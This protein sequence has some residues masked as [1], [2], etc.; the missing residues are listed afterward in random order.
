[1][2]TQSDSDPSSNVATSYVSLFTEW[3]QETILE[4][5]TALLDGTVEQTL[6]KPDVLEL[7]GVSLA[8]AYRKLGS[9]KIKHDAKFRRNWIAKLLSAFQFSLRP[10]IRVFEARSEKP[11]LKYETSPENRRVPPSLIV[12]YRDQTIKIRADQAISARQ[13]G[14]WFNFDDEL[15]SRVYDS[16]LTRSV[17]ADLT[18]NIKSL[19]YIEATYLSRMSQLTPQPCWE[20]DHRGA[21]FERL[22]LDVL[23][24]SGRVARHASLAEDILERTDLRLTVQSMKRREGARV[25]VSL[26]SDLT[27]QRAKLD[28]MYLPDEFVLL[29]PLTLATAAIDSTPGHMTRFDL[30]ELQSCFP[31]RSANPEQFAR[32]LHRVFIDAID[33]ATAHPTGPMWILPEAL[34]QFIRVYAESAAIQA[35]D[36]LRTREAVSGQWRGSVGRFTT[37]H[38]I[39]SFATRASAQEKFLDRPKKI[40]SQ[41]KRKLKHSVHHLDSL[42]RTAPISDAKCRKRGLRYTVR[43]GEKIGPYGR[44]IT[45]QQPKENKPNEKH[46]RRISAGMANRVIREQLLRG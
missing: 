22:L 18:A 4:V 21:Q 37:P 28:E 30:E 13:W 5:E 3:V 12:G 15:L 38:W 11:T 26:A 44:L 27:S 35:T 9:Y 25:Q 23:N 17:H 24:E 20:F 43:H 8:D 29:T 39:R 32:E 36:R 45:A 42:N 31:H 40:A 6:A 16:Y 7:I 33:F 1:M 14:I 2:K 46:Y 19:W 34:R 41:R 10:P